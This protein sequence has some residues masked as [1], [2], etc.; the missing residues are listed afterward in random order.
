M[1][2]T[3]DKQKIYFA[4]LDKARRLHGVDE[5]WNMSVPKSKARKEWLI[6]LDSLSIIQVRK[7]RKKGL[8][9]IESSGKPARD[10]DYLI[11]KDPWNNMFEVPDFQY[12]HALKIPKQVALKIMVLG[13]AG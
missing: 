6:F 9:W 4:M 12:N 13:H 10:K 11:V 1:T 5:N 8:Y 7:E 3:Y 2:K